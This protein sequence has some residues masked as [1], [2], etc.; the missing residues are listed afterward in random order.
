MHGLAFWDM[1]LCTLDSK[2]RLCVVAVCP[3]DL[4]A[5]LH[6]HARSLTVHTYLPAFLFRKVVKVHGV[7]VMGAHGVNIDNTGVFTHSTT[8]FLKQ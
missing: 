7:V 2:T 1:F 8:A 5:E 4:V 3:N 6:V